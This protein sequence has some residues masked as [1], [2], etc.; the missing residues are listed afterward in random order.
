MIGGIDG[1]GRTEGNDDAIL[2]DHFQDIGESFE[3]I[4]F[5]TQDFVPDPPAFLSPGMDVSRDAD[6]RWKGSIGRIQHTIGQ[7]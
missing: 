7:E 1:F 4:R 3:I 5:G 2:G 6:R